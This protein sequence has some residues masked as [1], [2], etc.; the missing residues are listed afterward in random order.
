MRGHSYRCALALGGS[1][2]YE[3]TSALYIQYQVLAT[4]TGEEVLPRL[5]GLSCLHAF[6][7]FTVDGEGI[8][9]AHARQRHRGGSIHVGRVLYSVHRTAYSS[10]MLQRMLL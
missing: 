5:T 3:R 2:R 8:M 1:L 4:F 10:C 9:V 6:A 7:T